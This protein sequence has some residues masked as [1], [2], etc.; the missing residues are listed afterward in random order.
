MLISNYNRISLTN[1]SVQIGE[2]FSF[3]LYRHSHTNSGYVENP[4]ADYESWTIKN[5][6]N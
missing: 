2:I 1:I 6:L 3:L 4:K 5:N